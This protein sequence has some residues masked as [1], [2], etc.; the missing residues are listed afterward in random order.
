MEV[1]WIFETGEL[2]IQNR[3]WRESRCEIRWR[4]CGSLRIVVLAMWGCTR[5][6]SRE[7]SQKRWSWCSCQNS[8][9]VKM[10]PI[11]PL[12]LNGPY[13]TSWQNRR[14]MAI[15]T[16]KHICH[17]GRKKLSIKHGSCN[18][19]PATSQ[20]WSGSSFAHQET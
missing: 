20:L 7:N 8:D 19:T 4:G 15:N 10:A 11:I 14:K 1:R 17:V 9:L 6:P 5:H 13:A 2:K 12:L 3:E 18:L 16:Y